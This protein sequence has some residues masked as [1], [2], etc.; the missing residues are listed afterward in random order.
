MRNQP[1]LLD[2]K[3]EHFQPHDDC[4]DH[5]TFYSSL[6]GRGNLKKKRFKYILIVT[7]I[8]ISVILFI[9]VRG[10]IPSR[11]DF[12]LP[13]ETL[14]NASADA[15]NLDS[16]TSEEELEK[17]IRR[18]K[19]SSYYLA[20]VNPD[21]AV[22][23]TG[24]A[25]FEVVNA[26][27]NS[28][29]ISVDLYLGDKEILLYQSGAIF[30]CQYIDEVQLHHI[31]KAGIYAAIAKIYIYNAETQEMQAYMEIFVTITVE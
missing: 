6:S 14:P 18:A 28:N 27:E 2:I 29:P 1:V 16:I 22:T 31:P 30:P 26:A 25:T 3:K 5:R 23:K 11:Y 24:I 20:Q 4:H 17:A 9:Y 10:L 7:I 12:P 13:M 8:V 21:I 19:N 15:K